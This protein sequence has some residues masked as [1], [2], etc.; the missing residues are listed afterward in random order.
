MMILTHHHLLVAPA[1]AQRQEASILLGP[2]ERQPVRD[3]PP[4][5]AAGDL[6]GRQEGRR[7][8]VAQSAVQK[9]RPRGMWLDL[10][11]LA[12]WSRSAGG[13]DK[14][15]EP[16]RARGSSRRVAVATSPSA[17]GSSPG[18]AA[19]PRRSCSFSPV[20][21]ASTARRAA[22]ARAPTP[23]PPGRR[24][25]ATL[26]TTS[27]LTVRPLLELL[28]TVPLPETGIEPQAMIANPPFDLAL[29]S[30]AR[31]GHKSLWDRARWANRR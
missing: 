24:A 13:G 9:Q 28:E 18:N 2:A 29:R 15:R 14:T 8:G 19:C 5:Q 27:H 26:G 25:Q 16:A 17:S 10:L 7:M 11:E 3:A 1:E 12:W 6:A 21:A 20:S 31:G 4:R 23:L 22:A 30:G